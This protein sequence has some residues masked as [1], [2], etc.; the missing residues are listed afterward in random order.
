MKPLYRLKYV[1]GVDT[2]GCFTY[3]QN[4]EK[5]ESQR[6]KIKK[7]GILQIVAGILFVVISFIFFRQQIIL[8]IAFGAFLVITGV[9]SVTK[10]YKD[11]N[12]RIAENVK[13]SYDARGYN[14]AWFEVKFFEDHVQYDVGGNLDSLHYNDFYRFIDEEKYFCVHFI[15]GDL[16]IFNPDV[17]REKIKEIIVS[18]RKNCD[19][20]EL[21]EARVDA[22]EDAV[23]ARAEAVEEKIEAKLEALEEKA[24]AFADKVEEIIEG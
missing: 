10:K 4:K 1:L 21:I 22:L 19:K 20:S 23:E 12:V 5:L 11:Y 16:I 24:E 15:T 3:D 7:M 18:Y 9:Q 6:E 8:S 17:D 2:Y 13:K 14:D